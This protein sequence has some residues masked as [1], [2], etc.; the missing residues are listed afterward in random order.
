MNCTILTVIL[1]TVAIGLAGCTTMKRVT[2]SPSL[3]GSSWVLTS[4]PGRELVPDTMPT[5]QFDDGRVAGSDGCNRYSMPYKTNGLN[6]EIGPTGPSTQMACPQS[7]MEQAEAFIAALVNAKT[8]QHQNGELE[9]FDANRTL[10]ATFA[11]QARSL[12]GT[13]W[14]VTNINN[15][16]Q[17]VVGTV[18]GSVVTVAFDKSGRAHGSTGCNQFTASYTAAGNALRFSNV[19]ATRR[20]CADP[21]MDEQ[22]RAFLR[23]IESVVTV[24]FEGDRVSLLQEDGAMAIVLTRE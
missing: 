1:C 19:A 14:T 7:T 3:D 6:I 5:A 9:L 24:R 15:G 17:A 16:R 10:V 23:A 2:H 4:L 13:S 11:E 8:F 18:T 20:A 12:A 21:A 22:E